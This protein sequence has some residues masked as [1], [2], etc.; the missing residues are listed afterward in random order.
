MKGVLISFRTY[1]LLKCLMDLRHFN[2]RGM[3]GGSWKKNCVR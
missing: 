1:A 2:E 3:G